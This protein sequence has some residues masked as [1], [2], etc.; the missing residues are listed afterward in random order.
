MARPG[1][2]ASSAGAD[3]RVTM[4]LSG[5]LPATAEYDPAEA[6]EDLLTMS[7]RQ[8]LDTLR[9]LEAMDVHPTGAVGHGLGALAGLAWAGV[10]GQRDVVEIA[11]LRGQFLQSAAGEHS[12]AGHGAGSGQEPGHSH[13][14]AALRAAVA[15]RFRRPAPA[16]MISTLTGAELGSVDD[17]IDLICT[18]FA[19]ADRL[20]DAVINGA[21]GATLLLETGP[22]TT[23]TAAAIESTRVPA[24][25]LD[26]GLANA[27]DTARA[28][29][30][31]MAGA[32]GSPAPL[33]AGRSAGPS[34]SGASEPSFPARAS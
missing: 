13:D 16:R 5:E 2:F 31:F 3:G 19:A 25:S 21:V 34:T 1:V 4:L 7:V 30:A 14:T 26:A 33:F 17:A 6:D 18:G 9:W 10:L 29:A 11:R 28:A 20:S 15:Q 32:L 24:V 23:L 8:C 27:A 12:A 22:G